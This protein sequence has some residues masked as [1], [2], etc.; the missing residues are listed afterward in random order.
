[1][2]ICHGEK[3]LMDSDCFCPWDQVPKDGRAGLCVAE[4][5][6]WICQIPSTLSLVTHEAGEPISPQSSRDSYLCPLRHHN[7]YSFPL[8][9]DLSCWL[10]FS[11]TTPVLIL[12]DFK[13]PVTVPWLSR[14]DDLI[15]LLY[16]SLSLLLCHSIT[17]NSASLPHP[18]VVTLPGN[19][20]PWF[21]SSPATPKGP[22]M[23]PLSLT[24]LMF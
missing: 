23:L 3:C 2:Q 18:T 4:S 19:Q 9:K 8:L 15:F 13:A 1:M 16:L 11:S 6:S 21:P 24:S 14:A 22:T 7:P 10:T 12:G 20:G 17:T 5:N